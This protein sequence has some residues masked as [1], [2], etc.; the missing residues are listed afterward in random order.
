[1]RSGHRYV[2]RSAAERKLTWLPALHRT[3]SSARLEYS[4][5]EPR[6]FP[7][8]PLDGVTLSWSPGYRPEP[9][10]AGARDGVSEPL[11]AALDALHAAI[12]EPPPLAAGRQGWQRAMLLHERATRRITAPIVWD[13]LRP[14]IQR[15]D[16]ATAARLPGHRRRVLARAMVEMRVRVALRPDASAVA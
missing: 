7:L 3:A 2:A 1:M 16:V 5:R 8:P 10:K 14:V 11:E 9:A 13:A 12:A 15:L 6:H 4:P